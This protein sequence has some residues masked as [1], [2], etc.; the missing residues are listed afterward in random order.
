[1]KRLLFA[2]AF[3]LTT[4]GGLGGCITLPEPPALIGPDIGLLKAGETTV[5]DATLL[6]GP[7][8]SISVIGD[9]VL[10]QWMFDI[11]RYG[12]RRAIHIAVSFDRDDVMHQITHISETPY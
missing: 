11:W 9:E 12:S 2:A 3:V 7:S 1:M 5:N 4:T 6:M 8:T 10:H